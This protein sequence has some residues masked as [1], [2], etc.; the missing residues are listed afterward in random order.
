[1]SEISCTSISDLLDKTFEYAKSHKTKMISN[2]DP[3]NRTIGFIADVGVDRIYLSLVNCSK[4]RFN[5]NKYS[6]EE[7]QLLWILFKTSSGRQK[8]SSLLS[9]NFSFDEITH[10]STIV[11][12]YIKLKAFI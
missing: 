11:K 2:D 12:A 5:G 4:N 3:Q 8:L 7:Q 10:F 1:M 9:Y 6:E